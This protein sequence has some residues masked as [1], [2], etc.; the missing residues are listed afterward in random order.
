MNNFPLRGPLAKA[1][2]TALRSHMY[3]TASSIFSHRWDIVSHLHDRDRILL[4]KYSRC[5][6]ILRRL[7][8]CYNSRRGRLKCIMSS[9]CH[10]QRVWIRIF[11][12]HFRRRT[13]QHYYRVFRQEVRQESQNILNLV[14]S[15]IMRYT[16]HLL[17]RRLH[18]L[19]VLRRIPLSHARGTQEQRNALQYV[20]RASL[21][22]K[23]AANT[24]HALKQDIKASMRHFI[25]LTPPR[26]LP[27]YAITLWM[28]HP[29]LLSILQEI[30]LHNQMHHSIAVELLSQ[31][32]QWI[33]DAAAHL[34]HRY[35]YMLSFEIHMLSE[36]SAV[37]ERHLH[38]THSQQHPHH[39]SISDPV[40]II[41][42]I[43]AVIRIRLHSVRTSPPSRGHHH[44]HHH[45]RSLC[46]AL[47]LYN[48]TIP[49][50][51][52]AAAVM[53]RASHAL[54]S[55]HRR[56][57]EKSHDPLLWLGREGRQLWTVLLHYMHIAMAFSVSS[58]P[59]PSGNVH[60]RKARNAN[61]YAIFDASNEE[62][63]TRCGEYQEN[64]NL[65]LRIPFTVK[66]IIE[67]ISAGI[68]VLENVDRVIGAWWPRR[69]PSAMNAYEWCFRTLLFV[70]LG[71]HRVFS[72]VL[73]VLR[74]PSFPR[75]A[76]LSP[77]QLRNAISRCLSLLS[78]PSEPSDRRPPQWIHYAASKRQKDL[79]EQIQ[80]LLQDSKTN[81]PRLENLLCHSL[82]P[83]ILIL[84]ETPCYANVPIDYSV[85]SNAFG[86]APHISR[87]SIF[88]QVWPIS[89]VLFQLC[90][91]P[92][93]PE[94]PNDE[95]VVRF[96]FDSNLIFMLETRPR[97]L[98]SISL[99]LMATVPYLKPTALPS[100]SIV[101]RCALSVV[102][103]SQEGCR[104][105]PSMPRETY[106]ALR[107]L[108]T[109]AKHYDLG[110][111]KR[112]ISNAFPRVF[113]ILHH[114]I[115]GTE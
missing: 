106:V 32:Q 39:S 86:N 68:H 10:T 29:R 72:S 25:G 75:A 30:F 9:S 27:P 4:A 37:M 40:R 84:E 95:D 73:V 13:A 113:E 80:M 51:F 60:N 31:A 64:S 70:S 89:S 24:F 23:S 22:V 19:C 66:E 17:R 18:T 99:I 102:E 49:Q 43:A 55:L 65:K 78:Q 35:P 52:D 100:P 85:S 92:F 108:H 63:Q 87:V 104:T 61:I 69:E 81:Q 76:R 46:D 62:I 93:L 21:Y 58:D 8:R 33:Q 67:D 11:L 101:W 5:T 88:D 36:I 114:N 47:Y 48:K 109:K 44:H 3:G 50:Q 2:L 94:S 28:L 53:E 112:W 91:N 6:S 79:L 56:R 82:L 57:K 16:R 7:D 34:K 90:S 20:N 41:A 83:W 110:I 45:R 15:L 98:F 103:G 74:S 42:A 54:Y 38:T 71:W 96:M 115:P 77:A 12:R 59:A 105:W 1:W 111:L 107:K 97:T 26:L 14:S